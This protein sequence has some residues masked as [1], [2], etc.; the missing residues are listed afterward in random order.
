[1][2]NYTFFFVFVYFVCKFFTFSTAQSCSYNVPAAWRS[3]GNIGTIFLPRTS[4]RL[5][6][7]RALAAG[8]FLPI[9]SQ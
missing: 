1:M 2:Q 5:T 6:P 9:L 8:D 4:A 7:N 3:G